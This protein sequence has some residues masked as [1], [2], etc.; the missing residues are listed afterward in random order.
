MQLHQYETSPKVYY[1]KKRMA[2]MRLGQENEAF[3][4]AMTEK[5]SYKYLSTLQLMASRYA[6]PLY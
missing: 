4:K 5:D 1:F 2:N 6:Y 3:I